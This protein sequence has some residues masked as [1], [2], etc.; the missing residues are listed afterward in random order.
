L[1]LSIDIPDAIA[2]RVVRALSDREGWTPES[3]ET[4]PVLAKRRVIRM[5]RADVIDAEA[6]RKTT[7]SELDT[8]S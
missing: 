8:I 2:P 4:R 5:I 6:E 1:I 3:T 7:D